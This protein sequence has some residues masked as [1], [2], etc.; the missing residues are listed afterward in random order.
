M[1]P[2]VG[3]NPADYAIRLDHLPQVPGLPVA[4][5]N[6]ASTA[7]PAGDLAVRLLCLRFGW[8]DERG[9]DVLLNEMGK[10]VRAERTVS[11]ILAMLDE[12]VSKSPISNAKPPPLDPTVDN[13]TGD[14]A[15]REIGVPKDK[16]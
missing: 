8:E 14:V 1:T 2:V 16:R 4:V 12:G 5:V 13:T 10:A 15:R 3:K 6:V 9:T 11:K 7:K